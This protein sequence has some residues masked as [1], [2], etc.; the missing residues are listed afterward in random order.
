MSREI[1]G[2]FCFKNEENYSMY[3]CWCE[4]S[5]E[6]E[7]MMM[8][9]EKIAR[10]KSLSWALDAKFYSTYE[11]RLKVWMVWSKD[12]GELVVPDFQATETEA[13]VRQAILQK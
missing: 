11:E 7:K 3:V 1:L 10:V 6:K 12:T 4:W 8:R 9:E 5:S 2:L 13:R